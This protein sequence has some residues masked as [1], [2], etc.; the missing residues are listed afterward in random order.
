MGNKDHVNLSTFARWYGFKNAAQKGVREHL[1]YLEQV[2]AIRIIQGGYRGHSMCHSKKVE[3]INHELVVAHFRCPVETK[4]SVPEITREQKPKEKPD[5]LKGELKFWCIASTKK[6]EY[7]KRIGSFVV[8][9]CSSPNKCRGQKVIE[10]KTFEEMK[11]W[12]D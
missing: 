11:H 4:A 10:T 9:I 12:R 6:C 5:F 3:V 1:V 7:K 2:G 8:P